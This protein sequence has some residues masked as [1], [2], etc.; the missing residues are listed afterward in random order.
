MKVNCN[1]YYV[2]SNHEEIGLRGAYVAANSIKPDICICVD[3]THATDYPNMNVI[4]DGDIKLG[5]GCV[6][7][8]GPNVYPKL[9]Q[10]LK[11][12]TLKNN[13][14]SQVEVSPY[15]TGTDANVVQLS[16]NG[17]KTIII[18]IPCRYMHTPYE[19]CSKKDIKSTIDIISNFILEE[20]GEEIN[21][22]EESL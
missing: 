20:F 3:V 21:I 12:I 14:T 1:L 11:E 19:M 16:T 10:R 6:L 17:V 2:A 8:K 15:P 4:S 18:S 7:S 13:I 22:K 9:F 5:G